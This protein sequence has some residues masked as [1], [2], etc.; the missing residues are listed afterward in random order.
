MAAVG[1]CDRCRSSAPGIETRRADA[2]TPDAGAAAGPS[3]ARRDD[4][5]EGAYR[6]GAECRGGRAGFGREHEHDD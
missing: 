4:L 2:L 5:C 3:T 6:G 1:L